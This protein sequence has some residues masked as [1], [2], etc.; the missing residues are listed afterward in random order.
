MRELSIIV[1]CTGRKTLVPGPGLSARD[2]PGV[3]LARRSDIWRD[4]V[5][6]APG[7]RR[8][9]R[10]LYKGDAWK[11]SILLE[12]HAAS[13]GFRPTLYVASAGLGLR[14]VESEAPGYAATFTLTHEDAVARTRL[15]AERWWAERC[16]D[17]G[18]TT[19]AELPSAPT[20]VVMSAA[21]SAP[22]RGDISR[23]A[24]SNPNVLVVGGEGEVAG[25]RRLP[26]NRSL[27]TE[28]G[29]TMMSL[30][31]RIAAAWLERL[32]G[33]DLL[34]EDAFPEWYAWEAEVAKPEV[35]D[36]RPMSDDSV[37]TAIR[38]MRTANPRLS[39]SEALRTLRSS[40]FACEQSRFGRLFA[41]AMEVTR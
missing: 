10:D 31:Q 41:R 1:T 37:M 5:L 20:M 32:D 29:G 13:V 27:R 26:G 16:V 21:Y 39:R 4:R 7:P 38:S 25:A 28:L 23:L 2:L 11:R 34:A 8:R 33:R 30:N 17:A 14:H 9:L 19:I 3:S 18:A 24:Q 36:R 12:R 22:L 15:D 40:G 6:G 35:W